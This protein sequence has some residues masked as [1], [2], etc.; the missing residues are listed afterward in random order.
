MAD[1]FKLG[2]AFIEVDPNMD[3]FSDKVKAALDKDKVEISVPVVPDT[4]DFKKKMTSDLSKD[5]AE[6]QV[7]VS[8]NTDGFK[9]KMTSALSKDRA[10]VDVDVNPNTTGFKDKMQTALDR[11]RGSVDVD[12][13]PNAEAFKAKLEAALAKDDNNKVV[14]PVTAD[15]ERFTS[16][17]NSALEHDRNNRIT[18]GV[19]ADTKQFTTDFNAALDKDRNN[20]ITVGVEADTRQF[21]TEFNS[22]L[23][24]DR[25]NKVTVGV[26]ADT[27]K[28]KLDVDKAV[29]EESHKH[30]TVTVDTNKSQIDA[31][32]GGAGGDAG[33]IFKKGFGDS[34][35]GGGGI[36]TNGAGAGFS[37]GGTPV[38]A[39]IA[40]L[41]VVGLAILP[42]TMAAL[43]A[44][45]GVALGGALVLAL[46][47]SNKKLMGDMSDMTNSIEG[48]LR[49]AVAPMVAPME[50]AFGQ[51]SGFVKSIKPELDTLFSDSAKYLMPFVKG[52][53]SLVSNILPGFDKLLSAAGP[54]VT[55]FSNGL[56]LIGKYMSQFFTV[57]IPGL[58]GSDAAF[59]GVLNLLGTL[60]VNV[61]KL[62]T[63]IASSL[64]PALGNLLT[65]VVDPLINAFVNNLGPILKA[66][67]PLFNAVVGVLAK[68][69]PIVSQLLGVLVKLV[70]SAL[71]PLIDAISKLL[72]YF[73]QIVGLV[74]NDL[75][76]AFKQLEPSIAQ[77][78]K[79]FG[80]MAQTI[81]PPLLN[82]F[83][84]AVKSV[85]PILLNL[86]VQLVPPLVKVS[87]T[88]LN[89][90][91]PAFVQ[92]LPVVSKLVIALTPIIGL[93]ADLIVGIVNV[94]SKFI[95]FLIK[96]SIGP[97]IKIMAQMVS[98]V[99][100]AIAIFVSWASKIQ[101]WKNL[102][103]QVWTDVKNWW[104]D[105]VRT[106]ESALSRIS[107][108]VTNWVGDV[109][110]ALSS[111]WNTVSRDVDAAWTKVANYLHGWWSDMVNFV[112]S[113]YT[114][115]E[116][117]LIGAWTDVF[118]T[119]Q[120]AW[121]A[122]ANFFHTW[123]SDVIN[124]F[125]G[126]YTSV[127]HGLSGAWNDIFN[128]AKSVWGNID[129]F[130]H[131]W[132]SNTSNFFT[133][134]YNTIRGNLSH[135]WDDV[136]NDVKV[137]WDRIGNFFSTF[138]STLKSGASQAVSG[139]RSIW[140]GLQNAAKT[141]VDFVVGTVYN[142]G[143]V[144]VIDAIAG[145]IGK[146][147]L[148]PISGYA[149][150]TSGAAPGWAWVGE[151][152][153]EL[154]KM[155]GGETVLPSHVSMA[156]G[157]W[158]SGNGYATGTTPEPG[159]PAAAANAVNQQN[160]QETKLLAGENQSGPLGNLP[161]NVLSGLKNV[162][163]DVL[164]GA[165]KPLK[166]LA[167]LVGTELGDALD[168]VLTPLVNAIPG[169]NNTVG[170]TIKGDVKQGVGEMVAWV[171]G[172]TTPA[173][174]G[175]SGND[176][177]AYAEQFAKGKKYPY[178]TGGAA[179]GGWDCSGFTAYIYDHFGYFPG[180][181]G[182][183]YGTSETQFADKTH[184]QASGNTP[185]ALVFFDDG[186]Y[187][188]PGHVGIVVNKD[189]YVSARGHAYGTVN[190]PITNPVGYRVPKGGFTGGAPA[191]GTTGSEMQN[192][193]EMFSY[194]M[195]NLFHGDKIASAGA[196]ASIYGESAWNPFAQGTGG[197]GLIGWTPPGTISNAAFK[198]GMATQLPAI[199]EFVRSN[200]DM[201]VIAEM[202]KST[203]ILDAANLWGKGVERYGINDVHST[204]LTLAAQIA[205]Q[206]SA[207]IAAGQQAVN[208]Q[209]GS[210]N[211]YAYAK[212]TGSAMP[213]W[214]W[215]GEAG[216][217]L[218]RM[219]GGETVLDNFTSQHVS[220]VQGYATGTT[221]PTAENYKKEAAKYEAEQ[222]QYDESESRAKVL[223][224]HYD[225]L[226]S[227]KG[228]SA[229]KKSSYE[230]LAS[231][232]WKQ[233]SEDAHKASTYAAEAQNYQDKYDQ[234]LGLDKTKVATAAAKAAAT[235]K[236]KAASLLTAE[237]KS[238]NSIIAALAGQFSGENLPTSGN[239][240]TDLSN[241]LKAVTTY[242]TGAKAKSLEDNLQKQANNMQNLA[243]EIKNQ[244]ANLAT[245]KSYATSVT[246]NLSSYASLSSLGVVPS[247]GSGAPYG[248]NV[249]NA[250]QAKLKSLQTFG[251]LLKSAAGKKINTSFLQ[252]AIALGPDGGTQY[253]QAILGGGSSLINTINSLSS[254]I[255]TVETS[256]GEQAA[257]DVYDPASEGK[258]FLVDLQKSTAALDKT[259][260][261]LGNTFAATVAK[262]LKIPAKDLPK[263]AAGGFPEAGLAIVGEQGPELV[264]F[265]KPGAQV[266][267]NQQTQSM[268]HNGQ[269]ITMNFY[270]TQH[271]T[272]EQMAVMQLELS[273][274]LAVFNV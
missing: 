48:T 183:R 190:A 36:G 111:A 112:T 146:H 149:S 106:I 3:G 50:K 61:G 6:V 124:F 119:V 194:F 113:A 134:A 205:G 128:T 77:I 69:A 223:A 103:N 42:A 210:F 64:G 87:T 55:M 63:D 14:V 116:N 120:N 257:N 262:D 232:Y 1:G 18:V 207:Q 53:E 71:S 92:L 195:S 145:I 58:K 107:K 125:S 60:L 80:E 178:V 140:A 200:G 109:T 10:N 28:F 214:A 152:G 8:P 181:Q 171:V 166:A 222:Y 267:N 95:D 17:F 31:A 12:L 98:G 153:P 219:V 203:S 40:S 108:D 35:R 159:T 248:K 4:K 32:M 75:I 191:G 176:V 206:N 74:G 47:S 90:W 273:K 208:T 45:S 274:Q 148:S 177:V 72:P 175:G 96:G 126:A 188:N 180:K 156:T 143:V 246:G 182:Q 218:V 44:A 66:L 93:L 237:Q 37:A 65:K 76:N 243:T 193:K 89:A 78:G 52:L 252:Q 254:Q 16:D 105:I 197:R 122:I 167:S 104:D 169:A 239:I 196:I 129:N 256:L 249:A 22:A 88:M 59:T 131:T 101:D 51:I 56:G 27:E 216:P 21:T 157:L 81:L 23:E 192:G 132:W 173:D 154:V 185:G 179:P 7:D 233:A 227:G 117:N 91:L 225:S 240:S 184:L 29:E 162:G 49:S 115:M 67:T 253:L 114:H 135:T 11:D 236:K 130:F 43:G 94:S 39:G 220:K 33:N 158:G 238:G 213:G 198:G 161:G 170:N 5:R 265:T 263:F 204:G 268:L 165:L 139:F 259:M 127:A 269:P 83:N 230:K 2:S 54:S 123:W 34:I 46:D 15:T 62:A 224:A 244:S 221:D 201:G 261:S 26:D 20:K 102:W 258:G 79:L 226:A 160:A 211:G 86:I 142:K 133:G 19:D 24:R 217:E 202:M 189:T 118:H 30:V 168:A 70:I 187:A 164:N 155:H 241:A 231:Q 272:A 137:V 270:G 38:V 255:S 57:L 228:L 245:A 41:V 235:A 150:G 110:S 97:T 85:L 212:G 234:R 147:P 242:Y 172:D 264:R 82:L 100:D 266:Y 25:N 151:K 68:L 163:S 250:L 9:D 73:G 215:V 174:G 251:E 136:F 209:S 13:N 260:V 144:P 138:W 121:S 141:P 199:I 271:P 84:Q 99:V 186:V 247:V 229:A